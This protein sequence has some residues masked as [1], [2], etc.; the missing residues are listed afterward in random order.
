M[1]R[2]YKYWKRRF[3]N[4]NDKAEPYC[5]HFDLR[6]I[7]DLDDEGFA[8]LMAGI[9]GVD[10]LDLNELEITNE[11]IRLISTMEYVKELR[12]K[13]CHKLDDGCIADLNKITSLEFLHVRFTSIT[14]DGLLHLNK[15]TNLKTLMFSDDDV[16]AIK[17]KLL[18]LKAMHPACEFIIDGKPYYFDSVECF[19]YA[20][21]SKPYTFRMKIKN[22]EQDN[23]WSNWIIKPSDS[24]YE[25]EKQ[26]PYPINEIEWIEVNPTEERQ[27]GKLI[28]VKQI[29]HTDKIV[30]L[31]EELTIPYMIV[32]PNIRIYL[33]REG[34]L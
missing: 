33:V 7:D 28:S 11:S 30:K 32:E 18:Q 5:H 34:L 13:G 21:R 3:G 2:N 6:R 19:I 27:D 29:V 20:V 15:L 10:M 24:Y 25:T 23:S 17:E 1:P 22:S 31:L 4:I 14:I 26:G 12:A 16:E 9:K 8:Y